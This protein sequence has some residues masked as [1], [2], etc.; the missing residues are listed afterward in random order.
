MKTIKLFKKFLKNLNSIFKISYKKILEIIKKNKNITKLNK[1]IV[2]N[3][4]MI[5]NKGQ[6]IWSRAK[7]VIPGGTSLFSKNPDLYLPKDGQHIFQKQVK[8]TFGI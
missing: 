4:G 5:N 1:N 6:K 3:E 2:R 7:K 8:F